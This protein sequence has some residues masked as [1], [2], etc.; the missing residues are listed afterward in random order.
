MD[1]ER[2]RLA[3]MVRLSPIPSPATQNMALLPLSLKQEMVNVKSSNHSGANFRGLELFGTQVVKKPGGQWGAVVGAV[4]EES[5][6]KR[7]VEN[8]CSS[9]LC[10]GR[11]PDG[12]CKQRL[13]VCTAAQHSPATRT[14]H[15][16]H[17]EPYTPL[18]ISTPTLSPS[19][20]LLQTFFTQ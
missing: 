2:I 6:R 9:S 1:E 18:V 8:V 13:Q 4:S 16:R 17:T 15:T 19:S 10:T 3:K 14:L 5:T 7:E 12:D 11:Q 20:S